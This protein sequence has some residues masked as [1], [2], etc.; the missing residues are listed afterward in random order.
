MRASASFSFDE[1]IAT[2]SWKAM[3]ALRSRVSMSAM[4]SVIVTAATPSP[5]RLRQAGD[6]PGVAHL[7]Q[8]DPAQ[9]EGAIHRARPAAAAT[10][11]V[12]AHLELRCALLLVDECL[13]GHLYLCPIPRDGTGSRARAGARDRG[14]RSRRS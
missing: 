7:A 1:G 8:T 13:L 14:R 5:R 3:F 12:T 10:A 9:A 11:R 2:S 6:L 4:G